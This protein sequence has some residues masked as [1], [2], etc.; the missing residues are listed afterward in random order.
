MQ[1]I[2]HSTNFQGIKIAILNPLLTKG[3]TTDQD[4]VLSSYWLQQ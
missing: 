3:I 2:H 1:V 4:T